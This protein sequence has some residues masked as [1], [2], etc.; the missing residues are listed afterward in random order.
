MKWLGLQAYRGSISWSRVQPEG[1]DAVNSQGLD[2]YS[3]LTD[4][5]LAAGITPWF[6]LFHWDLPWALQRDE[7][8]FLRR[9]A[10]HRFADYTEIV[11][12]AL[13]DRVKHWF[14]INEP[15]EYACFGHMLGIHAPGI[16]A[17]WR[18]F[19]V[20]HHI[21]LAHGLGLERIRALAPDAQAGIVLSHTPL[22]PRTDSAKDRQAAFLADQFMNRITLDPLF[23]GRYPEELSRR[24]RW[25]APMIFP[26]DLELISRKADFTGLNY[27]SRETAYHQPFMPLLGFSVTGKDGGDAEHDEPGFRTTAMGWEVWPQGLADL[28][29]LLRT[30]YGNPPTVIAENGAAF[31]DTVTQEPEGTRVH[32]PKRV[33][34]LRD[35]LG[36]LNRAMDEGADV[37]GF[38]TWS[39]MDNFEWAEGYRPRFGLVHVDYPTL[40][41]TIK[42][43]GYWYRDLIRASQEAP[44]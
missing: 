10:A 12:R 24:T 25:I 38:F 22:R 26:G 6:T 29:T 43:S 36:A 4:E 42:D 17:P 44:Q 16:R 39:L 30:E 37:R 14:T 15:F 9:D 35:Y 8:G 18:Y 33:E 27:Y 11:V 1:R 2:F 32:D 7:R 40:T 19:Q 23:K 20:M 5:L 28:A 21:L 41:R 31:T 34:F 3:R 13:G